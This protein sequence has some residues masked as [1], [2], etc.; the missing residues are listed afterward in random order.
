MA[1][2]LSPRFL[3]RGLEF[4]ALASVVALIALLV[5]GDNWGASLHAVERLHPGWVL[6]ALA[7]ASFDWWGGG[8]RIWLLSKF[9]YRPTRY[10]SMVIAAGLNTW[11]SYLTPSQTGG[12]PMM[13]WA[14]GRGGVPLPEATIE[15]TVIAPRMVYEPGHPFANERGFVAYPGVDAA[16]EMVT[17]MTALRAYEANVAAL[18]AAR[19][20][21]LRAL[22][23]GG[24]T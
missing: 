13:I 15:P 1:T 21:T 7:L 22:D 16:T 18:N 19:T 24:G 5:Y 10:R 2:L 6:A 3:K 20:M 4:F 17:I 23:I 14:M 12:G 9:L 11:G 8:V